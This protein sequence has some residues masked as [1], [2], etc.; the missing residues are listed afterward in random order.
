AGF[1]S[2]GTMTIQAPS[3][4]LSVAPLLCP[5]W[6]AADQ[7]SHL[8][9]THRLRTDQRV[10]AARQRPPGPTLLV[11]WSGSMKL[12]D[13]NV[14]RILTKAPVCPLAV[15]SANR[16]EG[17]LRVLAQNGKRVRPADVRRPSGACNVIDG[18]ALEWLAGQPGPRLWL[19]DGQ[20]TGV[21]DRP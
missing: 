11:D 10:F 7:G 16:T 21:Q 4:P 3:R 14:E 9:H 20:V 5:A 8:R 17:V 15:Y 2:W 12:T 19:S 13:A 6:R 18:P 1:V